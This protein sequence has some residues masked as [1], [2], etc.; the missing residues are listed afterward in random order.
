MRA[1]M[2]S[3]FKRIKEFFEKL[4]KKE[5]IRLAALGGLVIAFAIIIVCI[6]GRTTYAHFSTSSEAAE[7]GEI[8]AALEAMGVQPRIEGTTIY[9]PEDRVFELQAALASQGYFSDDI[10]PSIMDNVTGFGVTDEERKKAY[11]RF[12]GE[13]IKRMLLRMD[14]IEGALTVVSAGEDSPFV[15]SQPTKEATAAVML[16]TKGGE[17][18]TP[19]EA[20][21]I[22][23]IV[24]TSLPGIKMENISVTDSNLYSYGY[25]E[26]LE[27]AVDAGPDIN[28]RI[29]LENEL[30]KRIQNQGEQFL[31]PIL[32]PGNVMISPS[33]TL[34]FDSVVQESVVF[35][36]PVDGE[37]DGIVRSMSEMLETQ[38]ADGT[39]G[40]VVGTDPNGM[41]T[42]EYPY[43]GLGDGEAYTSAVNERNYEIN[44]TKTRIEK[45]QGTIKSLTVG[46]AVDSAAVGE[47]FDTDE[48]QNLVA[49][50]LGTTGASVHVTVTPFAD[51]SETWAQA[52]SDERDH[53]ARMKLTELIQTIIMWAVILLLGLAFMSL[54][55]FVVKKARYVEEPQVAF[56][57]GGTG[58]VGGIEYMADDELDD[59]GYL[60]SDDESLMTEEEI[61]IKA[62]QGELRQVERFID[63]DARAVAQLLRNWL[64]E[65]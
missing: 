44:E 25:T 47:D 13:E 63:K 55:R 56:A 19:R 40:G 59:I 26:I 22:I 24:R 10:D 43:G 27:D 53:E 28:A 34:D 42:V 41:G 7:A 14:K 35:A 57:G 8:Y 9:V 12:R 64:S 48:W 16:V 11:E 4:S 3:A 37:L 54:I 30:Q 61:A 31:A 51:H 65:E 20:N 46:V 1:L 32:G 5:K 18:L 62:K 45:A 2:D 23:D 21:S 17:M 36:P 49:A 29:L 39:A 33:V 52:F 15:R 60:N 50:A 38:R 58:G 6:L